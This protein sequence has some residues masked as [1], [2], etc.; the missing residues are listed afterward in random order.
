MI[1]DPEF[2]QKA[3]IRRI[4]WRKNN[5]ERDKLYHKKYRE[6]HRSLYAVASQKRIRLLENLTLETV[7]QVYEENIQEYGKP[8]CYLCKKPI[9]K[10]TVDHKVP[11]SRKDDFPEVNIN[12]KENLA[13]A[14]N[15]CNCRKHNKTVEEYILYL[16]EV[17]HR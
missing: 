10:V 7:M 15:S 2:K 13:I 5:K 8:T 12:S 16:K 3:A 17:S 6:S 11:V 14:C 4:L 1:D 9:I